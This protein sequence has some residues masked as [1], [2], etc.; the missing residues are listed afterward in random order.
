[1]MKPKINFITL[2]VADLKKAKAFY[3]NAFNFPV[4]DETDILCLFSLADD[5][6]LA[7]E[8]RSAFLE[9]A[10][11]QNPE[12]TSAGFILS[13]R[14]HSL[15]EVNQIVKRAEAAGANRVKTTDEDWGYSI[16]LTDPDGHPWEIVYLVNAV[17]V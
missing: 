7:L 4:T 5:F 8:E 10:G 17:N 1:M 11:A 13:H 3:Q 9:Q 6:S 15:E 14:A 12:A 2:A 16:I